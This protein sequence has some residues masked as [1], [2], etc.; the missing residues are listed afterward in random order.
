M[1]LLLIKLWSNR[2]KRNIFLTICK[3]VCFFFDSFTLKNPETSLNTAT[4]EFLKNDIFYCNRHNTSPELIQIFKL[5]LKLFA[6]C[7][8]NSSFLDGCLCSVQG[9]WIL[10]GCIDSAWLECNLFCNVWDF[11]TNLLVGVLNLTGA[12]FREREPSHDNWSCDENNL[13]KKKKKRE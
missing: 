12:N 5:V 8:Q 3:K 4:T 6:C 2:K 9:P 11:G 1:F 13:S 7:P 10:M